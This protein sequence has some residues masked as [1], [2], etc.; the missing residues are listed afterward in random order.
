MINRGKKKWNLEFGIP[1][2]SVRRKRGKK[3]GILNS[4][5]KYFFHLQ[6]AER[7]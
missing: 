2:K 3:N 4:K 1:K 6:R 7:D 5:Q